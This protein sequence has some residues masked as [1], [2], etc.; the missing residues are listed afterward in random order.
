MVENG[1]C[2]DLIAIVSKIMST[3]HRGG[4]GYVNDGLWTRRFKE[5]HD[6]PRKLR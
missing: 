4:C 6:R 1:I 5:S 3:R 2:E